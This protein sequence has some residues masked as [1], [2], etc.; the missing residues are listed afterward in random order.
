MGKEGTEGKEIARSAECWYD[1]KNW[2]C[3]PCW[4]LTHE[5]FL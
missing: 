4:A 2:N 5:K 1:V 3:I